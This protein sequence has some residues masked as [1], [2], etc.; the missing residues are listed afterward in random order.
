M[1]AL[2]IKQPWVHA[3]LHEGK[4]IENRSWQRS[5]RGWIA[6]HSAAKPRRDVKFRGRI[7]VPDL[8][9]LDYSAICGVARIADIV[10]KSSSKWFDHPDEGSVNYGWMLAEVTPLKKPIPCMQRSTWIVEDLTKSVPGDSATTPEVET[11]RVNLLCNTH[12]TA[13]G[14]LFWRLR[15]R[16]SSSSPEGIRNRW[17]KSSCRYM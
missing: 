17:R 12:T 14:R 1:K 5:F 11:G 10:T 13:G 16:S 15:S 8:K 6:I 3:I 2:T 4:D 7:H 9:T